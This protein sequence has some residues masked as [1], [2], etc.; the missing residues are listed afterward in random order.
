MKK[1]IFGK[2]FLAAA[3]SVAILTAAAVPSVADEVKG[4]IFYG[5][6]L[7]QI[8]YGT[9]DTVQF[10][11]LGTADDFMQ[12]GDKVKTFADFS[13]SSKVFG[14]FTVNS[15]GK[16]SVKLKNGGA[17]GHKNI[18]LDI[19]NT[20]TFNGGG[21]ADYLQFELS[22]PSDQVLNLF[23]FNFSWDNRYYMNLKSD[24]TVNFYDF[25]AKEWTD[26]KTLSA[27]DLYDKAGPCLQVPAGFNGIVR[28]PVLGFS[29][30][31][32][33]TDNYLFRDKLV[34]RMQIFVH[35]P[36]FAMG[37]TPEV[38][39][40]NFQW[41]ACG[42]S[43][44]TTVRSANDAMYELPFHSQAPPRN[45][46]N[47]TLPLARTTQGA[48]YIQFRVNNPSPV[49]CEMFFVKL[50]ADGYIMQLQEG[51]SYSY[52]NLTDGT[53]KLYTVTNSS[54]VTK[55]GN[56]IQVPALSSGYI[57]IPLS[58][59]SGGNSTDDK[60]VISNNKIYAINLYA[61]LSDRSKWHNV[62]I[63]DF[64]WGDNDDYFLGDGDVNGDGTINL[65]DLVRAKK[66][67]S[68]DKTAKYRAAGL[69]VRNDGEIVAEDII[70]VKKILL[71]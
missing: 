51:T 44:D 23:Y 8:T 40:D 56:C 39:F 31:A 3:V 38:T 55:G 15:E 2:P 52:I 71:K 43:G 35:S 25:A 68:G 9:G 16:A 61:E 63:G 59:F 14:D 21:A 42:Y 60:F 1:R 49:A 34:N 41:V 33:D 5:D 28:I 32:T 70:Q 48:D 19:S 6:R 46:Y 45:F 67:A 4:E 26:D 64:C 58:A 24:V 69:D 65:L 22:N 54:S 11:E 27:T 12:V 18:V 10:T 17:G 50:Y 57:R 62:V 37:T 29:G 53:K 30:G 66:V 36:G 13:D 7:A 47:L 20:T